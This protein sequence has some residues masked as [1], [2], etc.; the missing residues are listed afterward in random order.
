M[1]KS[2]WIALIGAGLLSLGGCGGA[3]VKQEAPAPQAA[4]KPALSDEATKALAAADAAIKETQ[5]KGILWTTAVDAQGKAHE[6]AKKNDS[7]MVIKEANIAIEQAKLGI[8][9]E[10]YPLMTMENQKM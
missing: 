4:A 9:Q 2:V 1:Q 6:A 7:A 5:A 8:A 10:G 3:A